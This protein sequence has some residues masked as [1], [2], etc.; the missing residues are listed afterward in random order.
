M[1]SPF[2]GVD[3]FL[4]D[5]A[6]WLDFHLRFINIWCEAV[7]E[8]LSDEYE[9]RIGERVYLVE[10]DPEAR[11]LILPDVA[12]SGG[13]WQTGAR[14]ASGAM[15][16]E[17]EVVPLEIPEGPRE[18]YI[19]ILHRPERSLVT[20]LELL[21]PTNKTNPGRIEYLQKRTA[22]LRQPVHLVELD[23]LQGGIRPPLKRA[24]PAGDYYYLISNYNSRPDALVYSWS[25]R[26][27]L[28]TVPIPLREPDPD[29]QIDLAGVFATAYDRGRFRR[30]L[31]Y[32]EACPAPLT[33][34]NQKWVRELGL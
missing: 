6:F 12:I 3:P 31:R 13:D 22:I 30:A 7:A 2:P 25:L 11:K 23:L 14:S 1:G 8:Q 26:D 24:W 20:V 15:L 10:H 27:P 34:E 18:A 17:P 4:E 16:L 21:S 28:P 9:A 19:E 33:A 32:R 5:P 29:I